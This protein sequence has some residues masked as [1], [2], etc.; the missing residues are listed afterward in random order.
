[1]GTVAHQ[2]ALSERYLVDLNLHKKSQK[3]AYGLVV[4]GDNRI[5]YLTLSLSHA[6][7]KGCRHRRARRAVYIS[8]ITDPKPAHVLLG[9]DTTLISMSTA[10]WAVERERY[11]HT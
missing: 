7:S 3:R 4:Q 11:I 9:H 6:G 2:Q 8:M 5:L 1:M 10:V